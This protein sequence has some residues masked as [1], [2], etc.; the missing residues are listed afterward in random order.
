MNSNRAIRNAVRHAL[1]LGALATAAG[2]TPSALAQQE[3]EVLEE[4]TVTGS[5]IQRQD[6]QSASPIVSLG[7]EA[8]RQS[9]TINAEELV[10][11]LPQI[12]PS[13]SAGNNNPGNG[14]SWLNLRG[15]GSERNLVLVDG[16]RMTP[17]NENAIVDINSI[18]VAMIER[19]EVISGGASAVYGSEAI[20]GATNFILKDRYNGAEI[21][22]HTGVSAENDTNSTNIEFLMGS[23]LAD[24]KGN[25]ML[26]GTFNTRDA[27][28]KGDRAFSAQAVSGTSFFPSGH[29]RRAAGNSWDLAAV[30]DVFVNLYGAEAP[31][32][33]SNL[34]GNDDGTL[35]TV[36]QG[37]INF[38]EVIGQDINGNFVAQNFLPN[39][40]SY[41]FEPFNNLVIPQDRL[42]FGA[43]MGLD[44]TESVELY[45]RIMF[46]NYSSDTKLA[47]SP[48]P[49]GSNVTNLL[50]G[51]EFTVPVTNPFVV[52]NQGLSQILASRTGD[53]VALPGTGADEDFIY[54]RRFIENGPRIESYERDVYQFIT[55]LRGDLTER[56][57]FDVWLGHGKYNEQLNQDGN[58]SVTRVESL[59]DAPDG[60]VSICEGGF[61]PVGANT[62][63][64]ECADYIGVL[65]KNTQRIEQNQIEA[66]VSGDV[67]ELPAGTMSAAVGAFYHEMDYSFKAD[68]IL[69]S[70]DVSGFNAT[71][72]IDGAVDN[73]DFFV[74]L[75]VPLLADMP[76]IQSLGLTTG[77]R[78]SDHNLAGQNNSYKAELDWAASDSLRFRGGYQR[79]VRAPNVGELFEPLNEDNPQVQD[80]CNFDSSFRTGPNAAQVA[81]LCQDQGILASELPLYSQPNAQ[82]QALQGGN[83]DLGEESADTYTIGFVYEPQFADG[84]Q[85][86]MDYYDIKVSEVITFIDPST[87]VNR[88][89]NAN[90]FNSN[91]D[92]NNEWCQKFQRSVATGEIVDLL[93]LQENIGGLRT[94]GIDLQVD[95]GF[96]IGRAGSLDFN[97]VS[98]YVFEFAEQSQPGDPWQDFAG[99]IGQDVA[100]A[101]PDTKS[102]LT[103]VWSISDFS[104]ALRL[105]YLPSMDHEETVINGSTDPDICGCTGVDSV[106]YADL[107]TR[108][109]ATDALSVRLG[110]DNLT[111]EEPQLFTPDQDSG[112]NPTVYDVIGQRYY[113]S[114]TYQ[115]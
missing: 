7:A 70:G 91:Y 83:P 60:G 29:I 69:A 95:Y 48:A 108:W 66:V 102:T 62:L 25:V 32:Q 41:N 1:C 107:S 21:T 112:T 54:R 40:Y 43:K 20:A 50:A 97:L 8:F 28:S 65:A 89:F 30:Q 67:I 56:W 71:D 38:R 33:L 86:S 5:R 34:V 35:F 111:D 11:T 16:K 109:Q 80:P 115:F 90:G 87:V 51:A 68:E 81:Q 73:T 17:A 44:L 78:L 42:N 99:T 10:N 55:G 84:L 53:N 2:Y 37:L 96:E 57:T 85:L 39:D 58:V 113:L 49:T 100:E 75:Y 12:V 64:A 114:A 14:Q 104:T 18:P 106:L 45:S 93:E 4:I 15:L 76:M 59:L 19:V 63:S 13:F 88:C 77:Y 23:D 105:R 82:I 110:I 94:D 9:G 26:W 46:T 52:A 101:Y 22:A 74:E 6:Y 79:A 24:G 3:A 27:L 36:D 92:V 61:N 98:T 72:N 47:P 103:T 31:Q